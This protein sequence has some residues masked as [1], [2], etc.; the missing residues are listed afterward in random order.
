MEG[1]RRPARQG[2]GPDGDART[3]LTLPPGTEHA[4]GAAAGHDAGVERLV[5]PLEDGVGVADVLP[6][7]E[8]EGQV[9]RRAAESRACVGPGLDRRD[10]RIH[11]RGE[12]GSDADAHAAHD[13]PAG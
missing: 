7:E 8:D 10:A 6:G 11:D 4:A 13:T 1:A 9:G 5:D 2:R 12:A 3:V